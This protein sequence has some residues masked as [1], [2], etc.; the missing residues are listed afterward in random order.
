MLRGVG[1]VVLLLAGGAGA[2]PKYP[3]KP[4][5]YHFDLT[6]DG[7]KKP[8]VLAITMPTKVWQHGDHPPGWAPGTAVRKGWGTAW[9]YIDDHQQPGAG[10]NAYLEIEELGKRK[11]KE[12]VQQ[13][14][15]A[16]S[17]LFVVNKYLVTLTV[18]NAGRNN[19]FDAFM[20]KI[21]FAKKRARERPVPF[22]LFFVERGISRF[23]TLEVPS[24]FL[25][26]Y[27]SLEDQKMAAVFDN[28][29]A[30]LMIRE[31]WAHKQPLR[32]IMEQRVAK[33]RTQYEEVKGPKELKISGRPAFEVSF[34]HEKK[35]VR[36][37][38]ARLVNQDYTLV[39]ETELDQSLAFDRVVASARIWRSRVR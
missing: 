2:D 26:T 18:H 36:M 15:A 16:K 31:T 3:D 12:A 24:G 14:I 25:R 37:V 5:K 38:Y 33:L 27:G 13:A 34:V 32:D 17:R 29:K 22:K 35:R 20:S 9:W 10:A 7:D 11:L 23:L 19:L 39:W 4:V 21:A 28:A 30:R 1:I 8:T 6:R